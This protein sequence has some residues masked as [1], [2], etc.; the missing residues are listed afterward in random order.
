ML[1]IVGIVLTAQR[2]RCQANLNEIALIKDEWITAHNGKQG[3]RIPAVDLEKIFAEHEGKLICPLDP[4]QTP[5]T[6]YEIGP[7]GTDPKCKFQAKHE[8][9]PNEPKKK[10][11]AS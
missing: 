7:I 2:Y 1:L 11:G 3:D 10:K 6:S 9:K 8:Q 4:N 5:Q